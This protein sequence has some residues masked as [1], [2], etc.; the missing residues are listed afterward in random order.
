MVIPSRI[1]SREANRQM[2]IFICSEPEYYS[3]GDAPYR[4]VWGCLL[5]GTDT[6]PQFLFMEVPNVRY[7]Q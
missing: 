5:L 4:E 6:S 1:N 3:C 7:Q 2:A